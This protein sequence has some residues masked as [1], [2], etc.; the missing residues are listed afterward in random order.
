MYKLESR[1]I[2]CLSDSIQISCEIMQTFWRAVASDRKV[3][4]LV[5]TKICAKMLQFLFELG[6]K[7]IPER[8]YY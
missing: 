7:C 1:E 4:I 2:K 3:G 6:N 8:C 5:F